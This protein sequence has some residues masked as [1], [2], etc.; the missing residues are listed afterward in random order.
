MSIEIVKSKSG[1]LQFNVAE[2]TKKAKVIY[3]KD[4][5]QQIA[6]ASSSKVVP[7]KGSIKC[8]NPL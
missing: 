1:K 8:N 2:F 5:K 4:V 6:R 7:S 3:N